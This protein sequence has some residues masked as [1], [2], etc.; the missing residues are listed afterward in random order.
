MRDLLLIRLFYVIATYPLPILSYFP[1]GAQRREWLVL[2]QAV[3]CDTLHLLP[4]LNV[5]N[6]YRNKYVECVEMVIR[7]GRTCRDLAEGVDTHAINSVA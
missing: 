6:F 3:R 1:I 4:P 5:L 7:S 2:R